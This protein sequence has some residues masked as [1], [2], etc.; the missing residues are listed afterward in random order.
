VLGRIYGPKR[1]EMTGGW[2]KLYNEELRNLH[3]S[4][5]INRMIK[6]RMMKWSGHTARKRGEEE[7]V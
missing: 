2:R 4:P 5:S 3:S 6:S 1:D 7:R